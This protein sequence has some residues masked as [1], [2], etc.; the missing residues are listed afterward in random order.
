MQNINLRF[1]EVCFSYETSIEN[2]FSDINISFNSGWTGVVGPNGIGKTTLAKLAVGLLYPT[3]GNIIKSK[4]S[5]SA[6]YCEQTTEYL[7]EFALDFFSDENNDSGYIKSI[8][9][10]NNDWI[11]NWNSL[12]HGERKRIQ[13]GIM[14]WKKHDIL[15]LDEPTNH[16]DYE[17]VCTLYE[18]LKDFSGIGIIISHDRFLLDKLCSNCLF[19]EKDSIIMRRGGITESLK[20]RELDIKTKIAN[21]KNNSEKYFKLSKSLNKQKEL[22]SSE[23]KRLSKKGIDK[24]DHS[25]RGEID[26]AR[27]TGK[28]KSLSQ[29]IKSL[30][31]KTE[32]AKQ[33]ME[34]SYFHERYISNFV[35]KGERAKCNL[36]FKFDNNYVDVSE[37]IKIKSPELIIKPEDKIAV[38]G[39]NGVGKSLLI[40]YIYRNIKIEP[41]KIIYIP[42]EFESEEINNIKLEI[43]KLNRTDLGKL[44]TIIFRLGSEPDRLLHFETLSPGEIRKIMFGLGIL[45]Q[46]VIIIMDEPTNHL[47]LP[48]IEKLEETLCDFV[49]ALLLVSHDLTFIKKLTTIEW[50]ISKINNMS[51]LN[52]K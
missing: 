47:D 33:E 23:K 26:L 52:I 45:K 12:S 6:F 35:F 10:I 34:N 13:I 5:L 31:N 44:Y 24:K 7:P 39:S 49:G 46:P 11:N 40:K 51:E 2:I 9:E 37:N 15:I 43:E 16:L 19:V 14:L 17:T 20:Q 27:L 22:L 18:G 32:K 41:N 3:S 29:K 4:E 50:N 28:D 36:L 30:D 8:L 48:S 21:Y 38:T 1:S 42:Q 25:K